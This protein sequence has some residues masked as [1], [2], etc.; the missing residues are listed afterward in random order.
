M[1][2]MAEADTS[3]KDGSISCALDTDHFWA[4]LRYTELNPMRAGL[5]ARPEDYR[6]SSA[7]AHLGMAA[8]PWLD[9]AQWAEEWNRVSWAEFLSRGGEAEAEAIRRNTHTGR[10]LGSREFVR[11]LEKMLGRRLAP[12]TGEERSGDRRRNTR[13]P[14]PSRSTER[15]VWW[16]PPRMRRP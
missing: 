12:Q 4:A 7:A 5:T 8:T 1:H 13:E 15:E 14:S 3:G 10:P 9:T 11:G 6:W 2:D 16:P